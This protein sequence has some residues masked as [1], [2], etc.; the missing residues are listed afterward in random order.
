MTP[1][2]LALFVN[3]ILAQGLQRSVDT[4]LVHPAMGAESAVVVDSP[5]AGEALRLALGSSWQYERQPLLGYL[6]GEL[7]GAAIEARQSLHLGASLAVSERSS[8]SLRALGAL[9]RPGDIA[10]P[11]QRLALG[12]LALGAKSCW[13]R[14][15]RLAL[16]PSATFWLPVGTDDSWVAEQDLRFAPALLGS[17]G[18]ERL[19]LLV[20][21]G[22]LARVAVDSGGDFMASSELGTGAALRASATP[23]L[24]GLVEAS[25][26]HGLSSFLRS[27]AE[28]PAEIKGG[29]RLSHRRLGRL[30]L[31]A[32]TGLT[33][34]YGASDLRLVVSLVGLTPS[35]RPE[36]EPQVVLVPPLRA[37]G[38]RLEE[39]PPQAVE[40]PAPTGAR[41]EH[42]HVVLDAPIDF[43]A[44]T[45]TLLPGAEP[46]LAQVAE[47]VNDYPQIELLV[48]EGHS[49]E[50]GEAGADFALSLQRA[51][52]VFEQ[53][54]SASV[55]P[56]RLAYRGMG[57][58]DA[59]G[60]PGVDF[61]IAR[62]RALQEGP[63]TDDGS[64]VVLPW[65]GAEVSAP[66][67]GA[68]LLGQDGHPILVDHK[69]P[70]SVEVEELPSGESFI[71]A[72]DDEEEPVEESP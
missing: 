71:E 45:A 22:L 11:A 58:G 72:L 39:P 25:S 53:L 37:E 21:L 68:R 10:A 48:V 64:A 14:R 49:Q 66:V 3:Q 23:W 56:G 62:V 60:K 59:Q 26:R 15:E 13:L 65:N 4:Q 1:L 12:D 18:G 41:V 9:Q 44:G 20:N 38:T 63:L 50:L 42:G 6:N 51:R 24:A 30:D 55:R 61:V 8:L 54:V 35:L 27:G 69:L 47:V 17:V 70:G 19:E 16:G 36:P 34:G 67:L 5:R 29:L 7:A 52:V 43:E 2:V 40:L 57:A 28:N 33:H 31:L 32:G 46:L